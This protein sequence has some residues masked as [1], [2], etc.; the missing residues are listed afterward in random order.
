MSVSHVFFGKKFSS[1]SEGTKATEVLAFYCLWRE[2]VTHIHIPER[3]LSGTLR[4][5][6]RQHQ[7][8]NSQPQE[9]SQLCLHIWTYIPGCLSLQESR[10]AEVGNSVFAPQSTP[11]LLPSPFSSLCSSLLHVAAILWTV[12][13]VVWPIMKHSWHMEM[14]YRQSL[15][16][17][18]FLHTN[19]L[20]KHVW[21]KYRPGEN[22]HEYFH[23]YLLLYLSFETHTQHVK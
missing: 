8:E 3:V 1:H 14:I 23:M 6:K 5:G 7:N 9:Q 2:E 17:C 20:N 16:S 13:V 15:A 18:L 12:C 10:E 11:F 4:E 22:L 19:W 21:A